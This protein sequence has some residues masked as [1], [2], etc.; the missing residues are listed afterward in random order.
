MSILKFENVT[1]K[2]PIYNASSQSLRK[3]IVR[4]G[5]GGRIG[6]QDEKLVT[7]TALENVSFELNDGDAV[8]LIGHNGAGKSTLLRTMAGIYHP[9]SGSIIREGRVAT[10]FELG[11][12]MDPELSGYENIMRM[13]MLMGFSKSSLKHKITDIEE[14]CE[15]GNFLQLPVRTYSSGMTMRLMFAVATSVKPEILL[16]DEMF[17]T[18]DSE[19]Q[20]K[21]EK[22]MHD[23]ISASDIFVFASHDMGLIKRLC[24]RFI[25]LAHGSI[26]EVSIDSI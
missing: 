26:E 19:F 2:Y 17:G 1:V 22:R 25:R 14:F 12:G 15:L 21:A 11:A 6:G 9:S 13:L 23:W 8:G 3:Q 24:N 4:I 7:V 16:I 5:T 20:N 18:G 10:V